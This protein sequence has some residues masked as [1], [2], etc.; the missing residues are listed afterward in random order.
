MLF[1]HQYCGQSNSLHISAMLGGWINIWTRALVICGSNTLSVGRSPQQLFGG[2][3]EV[4]LQE[5]TEVLSAQTELPEHSA[6]FPNGAA[7]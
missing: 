2:M 5:D 6:Q 3:S 4:E 7:L 1:F